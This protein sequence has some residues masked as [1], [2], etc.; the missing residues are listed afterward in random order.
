MA[1]IVNLPKRPTTDGLQNTKILYFRTFKICCHFY[2]EFI[3][4][5][6][7]NVGVLASIRIWIFW[8]LNGYNNRRRTPVLSNLL[9]SELAS[10]PSGDILK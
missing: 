6:Y 4:D 8:D 2:V 10:P 3:L 7:V 1:H 9:V 5:G